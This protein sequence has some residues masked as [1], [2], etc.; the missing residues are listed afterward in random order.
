MA[1]ADIYRLGPGDAL[2]ITV[3]QED[4]LS[5]VGQISQQGFID[6]P[7]LGNIELNGSSRRKLKL[8]LKPY[9]AKIIW[10]SQVSR[11]E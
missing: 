5:F 11:C 7:L 9:W 6:F 1:H 4:D 10:S 2:H 3:Y 8:K